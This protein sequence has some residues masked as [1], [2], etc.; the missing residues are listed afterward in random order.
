MPIGKL[1]I[2][3]QL[4]NCHVVKSRDQSNLLLFE[5]SCLE[6]VV[7]MVENYRNLLSPQLYHP[8]GQS[9]NN[10]SVLSSPEITELQRSNNT[11]NMRYFPQHVLLCTRT[12]H[13][14]SG[15][16][17]IQGYLRILYINN[18]HE[19]YFLCLK[20]EYFFNPWMQQMAVRCQSK[21]HYTEP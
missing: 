11:Y 19:R 2:W 16:I 14:Q 13:D 7:A 10:I 5:N 4:G 3:G 9:N 6:D 15:D 17:C 1:H 12:V 21:K 8:Q 20:F 18:I